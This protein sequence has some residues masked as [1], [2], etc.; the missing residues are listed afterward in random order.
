MGYGALAAAEL[1]AAAGAGEPG[2]PAAG[3]KVLALTLWWTIQQST[4]NSYK[5]SILDSQYSFRRDGKRTNEKD[6][7]CK[8]YI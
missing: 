2:V 5:F 6:S 4:R 1:P 8:V 3:D 7:M